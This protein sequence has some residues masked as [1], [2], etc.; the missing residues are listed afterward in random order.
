M[1]I[2]VPDLFA[3][4]LSILEQNYIDIN[5]TKIIFHIILVPI[6]LTRAM[7]CFGDKRENME[8]VPPEK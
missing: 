5:L 8:N 4:K 3:Q 1:V 6:C 7:H 2:P